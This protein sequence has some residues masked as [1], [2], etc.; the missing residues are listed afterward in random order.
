MAVTSVTLSNNTEISVVGAETIRVYFK[1]NASCTFEA[2]LAASGSTWG[3]VRGL[4]LAAQ[5][6]DNGD[7]KNGE[8]YEFPVGVAA[9]FRVTGLT[10]TLDI[11]WDTAPFDTARSLYRVATIGGLGDSQLTSGITTTA[12]TDQQSLATG[13]HG[14]MNQHN[15]LFWASGYSRARLAYAGISGDT[16]LTSA[17]ILANHLA[18][19]QARRWTYCVISAGTNDIASTVAASTTIA[20]MRQMIEGLL[21]VGTIPI[22]GGVL[23]N[24]VT[25]G[26]AYDALNDGYRRLAVEYR[27]PFEDTWGPTV[28]TDGLGQSALFRDN[29]HLTHDAN[30]ARGERLATLLTGA[31]PSIPA[32]LLPWSN[33]TGKAGLF[34]NPIYTANSGAVTPTGWTISGT[35]AT[36]NVASGTVGNTFAFTRGSANAIAHTTSA[37]APDGA[38]YLWVGGIQSSGG[39]PNASSYFGFRD[40]ASVAASHSWQMRIDTVEIPANLEFAVL[41]SVPTGFP[42]NRFQH[43][44]AGSSSSVITLQRNELYTVDA[45]Q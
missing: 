37:I 7:F 1:G 21:A 20:N 8:F 22:I 10:G 29:T 26:A 3:R 18:A 11:D 27:V 14:T 23:S 31:F 34:P 38:T 4:N 45:W 12:G 43:Q 5:T 25:T 28:G 6:L 39:V 9:R 13:R 36:S 40:P 19:A 2:S 24:R 32:S 44:N 16:G 30:R 41:F 17:Q 42:D 35:G 15:F 33:A